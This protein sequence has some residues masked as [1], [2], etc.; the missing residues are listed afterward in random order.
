[1]LLLLHVIEFFVNNNIGLKMATLSA[2]LNDHLIDSDDTISVGLSD[3][4]D[5]IPLPKLTYNKFFFI[6]SKFNVNKR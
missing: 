2:D 3:A 4:E 1:M 5:R 6:I